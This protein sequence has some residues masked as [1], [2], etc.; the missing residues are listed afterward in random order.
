MKEHKREEQLDEKQEERA[1]VLPKNRFLT[2]LE[3][4]WYHYKF[5]TIVALFVLLCI[6]G[7][8]MQC[9][10]RETGD[11]TIVYAGGYT[12]LD[13]QRAAVV[14]TLD[15][16]M[17]P[18]EGSEDTLTTVFNHYSVYSEEELRKYYTDEDGNFDN[19]GFNMALGGS[20]N[21]LQTF[22]DY[23]LTGNSA[24]YFVRESVYQTQNMHKLARPLE[25]SL[26][27]KP[28]YAYD[29]YA[30]RL[31]DT[32]LYQY[33]EALQFFPED[34][35]IVLTEPYIYGTVSNDE[36]YAQFE[37]LFRAIVEFQAP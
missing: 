30:I 33:Y 37:A 13:A 31:C 16:L 26:G 2:W 25:K 27:A 19:Y 18:K 11:I 34:T 20:K 4:F 22:A 14:D 1:I 32:P 8:F 6:V 35:L 36:V 29:E 28:E 3:N 7:C 21:N 5:H 10:G 23:L 17:I 24:L 15:S 12:L 9:S